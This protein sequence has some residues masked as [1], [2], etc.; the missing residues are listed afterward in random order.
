MLYEV[1]TN[2]VYPIN[3]FKLNN[4]SKLKIDGGIREAMAYVMNGGQINIPSESRNNFV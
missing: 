1:I 3:F 2:A 4:Y